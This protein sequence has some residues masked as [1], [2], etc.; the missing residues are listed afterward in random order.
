MRGAE[1]AW[2]N[3][4][5]LQ[6]LA[7]E[8]GIA[9]RHHPELAPTTQLRQLQY[10]EDALTGAGKRSR[11]RLA[12]SYVERYTREILDRADLDSFVASLPPAGRSA[13]MCVERDAA[14]CHRSLI[15]ARVH[16]HYGI[17]VIDLPA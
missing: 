11:E 16:A 10:A 8:A 1:Y 9:Y 2:A 3:S 6:A 15:A 7:A 13:L 17:E 5:R 14:A 4:L 12:D